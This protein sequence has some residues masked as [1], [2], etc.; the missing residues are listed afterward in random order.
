MAKPTDLA[1]GI[2]RFS[3]VSPFPALHRLDQHG[4]TDV[5]WRPTRTGRMANFCSCTRA[6]RGQM[7]KEP[8][9]WTALSNAIDPVVQ[10]V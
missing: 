2:F 9:A 6:G 8:A 10:E 3:R 5:E 7:K 4:W 1:P